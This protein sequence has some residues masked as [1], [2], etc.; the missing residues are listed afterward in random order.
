MLH[1]NF[2]DSLNRRK[3]SEAKVINFEN[4]T[5]RSIV[6]SYLALKERYSSNVSIKITE[7]H[8]GIL[9]GYFQVG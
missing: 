2:N 5:H 4:R 3:N 9:I 1:I 6:C 7:K 8:N